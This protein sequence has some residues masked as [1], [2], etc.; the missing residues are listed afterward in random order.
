M[1]IRLAAGS[2][3]QNCLRNALHIHNFSKPDALP[4]LDRIQGIKIAPLSLPWLQRM[5]QSLIQLLLLHEIAHG[6]RP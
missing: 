4:A 5:V 6:I 1:V 2:R 3:N